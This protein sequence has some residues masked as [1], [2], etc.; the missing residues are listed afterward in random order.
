MEHTCCATISLSMPNRNKNIETED[1]SK[2]MEDTDQITLV[3]KEPNC[4]KRVRSEE[5]KLLNRDNGESF[6]SLAN[7]VDGK[8]GDIKTSGED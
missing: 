4:P 8:N 2:P 5:Q 7:D 3:V 1:S 6:H